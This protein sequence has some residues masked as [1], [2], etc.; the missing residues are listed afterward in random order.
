MKT[1]MKKTAAYLLAILL[2]FQMIPALAEGSDDS[3][4]SNVQ[5]PIDDYREKLNITAVTETVP[6]G[7]DITLETTKGYDKL[8]WTSEDETVATVEG[9]KVHPISAGTVKIT[10][11]EDGYTDSITLRVVG[12]AA[13]EPE[14]E[15]KPAGS[16][17]QPQDEE[18]VPAGKIIII[19]NGSKDKITYDGQEHTTSYTA[20]SNSSS[21]DENKLHLN[22]ESKLA[23]GKECGVYQDTFTD[24]DFTYDEGEYEIVVTAG[25]LQIKPVTATIIVDDKEMTEGGQAPELTASISGLASADDA[26]KIK[27]TLEISGNKIIAKYDAVQGNYKVKAVDGDLTI[28]Q[29]HSYPLY[30]L[31]QIGSTWYRLAKTNIKTQN[32]IEEYV[33]GLKPTNVKTLNAA[34]YEFDSYNFEDLVIENGGKKY[35]YKCE[36]NAEAIIKGAN[37]YTASVKEVQAVKEKIGGM[38]GN[39]PRWLVPE[40]QRYDDD[41]AID[42][43]HLNYAIKLNENKLATEEQDIINMLSVNGSGNYHR[44]RMTKI[45]AVPASTLNFGNEIKKGEYLLDPYDFTDIELV[46]DGET[47]KYSDHELTGEYESYYTVQLD[48]VVYENKVNKNDNWFNDDSGWLD[49]AKEQYGDAGNVNPNFHAN[50]KATTHK[51][52]KQ[53]EPQVERSIELTSDYNGAT[54]YI[55]L[56]ITLTATLKGYDGLELGKD[57]RLKWQ[58]SPKGGDNWVDIEGAE[59]TQYTF[60]LDQKTTRY[61]WRV[62]AEDI[63]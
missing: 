29:M 19:I 56:K 53:P 59:G 24:A 13:S 60:T 31:A 55:G 14:T 25:W 61:S 8:Q 38:N 16:S 49:G 54:G 11:S 36:K 7:M 39:T 1:T 15:S 27:Y 30:N 4:K 17:E 42:C 35:I 47:Y 20:T 12:T 51:G 48:R 58:Y 21:F 2:V 26:S 32:T 41:N 34:E 40:D 3:I 50:Y 23:T 57:Y 46:I 63:K 9:G 52:T 62:I 37:Y 44:L 33:K 18:N 10:A 22:D 45:T 43:F 28:K 6:V 5:G